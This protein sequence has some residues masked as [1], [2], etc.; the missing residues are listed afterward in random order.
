MRKALLCVAVVSASYA[1]TAQAFPQT[2]QFTGVVTSVTGTAGFTAPWPNVGAVVGD[3][4]SL[5]FTF[6]TTVAD[7][8]G[9]NDV[10]QYPNAISAV[11]YS[12]GAATTSFVPTSSS[13]FLRDNVPLGYDLYEVSMF[14]MPGGS[15]LS[16]QLV[17]NTSTVFT[18]DTLPAVLNFPAFNQRTIRATAPSGSPFTT[19]TVNV[20]LDT[21]SVVVPE[22]SLAMVPV[23]ALLGR[24]RRR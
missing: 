23:L 2:F 16:V 11:T 14:P 20:R 1:S 10:G 4:V 3:P 17:D 13:F 19:P 6:E 18:G 9:G 22:P 7:T 21:F 5:T 12:M 8:A 15:Q 24:R